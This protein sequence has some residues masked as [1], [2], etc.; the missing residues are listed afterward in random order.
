MVT[1]QVT[2]NSFQKALPGFEYDTYKVGDS[3]LRIP[4]RVLEETLAV[5]AETIHA[6]FMSAID[7]AVVCAVKGDGAP[8]ARLPRGPA[9]LVD[10]WTPGQF[11][12]LGVDFILGDDGDVYLIEFSKAPGIRDV[13]PF[14]EAQNRPLMTE[15]L[16]LVLAARRHW[17]ESDEAADAS[18]ASLRCALKPVAREW[19]LLPSCA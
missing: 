19:R 2:N 15:A 6:R 11:A 18:G 12:L 4:W 14:L 17:I 8:R 7:E 10:G 3:E 9:T 13:P 1:A 16:D 5:D